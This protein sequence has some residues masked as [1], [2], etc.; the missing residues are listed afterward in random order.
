[1]DQIISIFFF[2]F[3][4][5][6]PYLSMFL[7]QLYETN[8]LKVRNHIC[9]VSHPKYQKKQKGGKHGQNGQKWGKRT[10]TYT[11]FLRTFQPWEGHN[12]GV[13]ALMDI[14]QKLFWSSFWVLQ[15]WLRLKSLWSRCSR[16]TSAWCMGI[17]GLLVYTPMMSVNAIF[18]Y[19]HARERP[20]H[21][22][23]MLHLADY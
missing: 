23:K 12:F 19:Y 14:I 2:I 20:S 4:Q 11:T 17:H 7:V 8:P 9:E 21:A 3:C 5:S 16:S 18:R 15:V 1:M 13:W 6:S 10:S 22:C